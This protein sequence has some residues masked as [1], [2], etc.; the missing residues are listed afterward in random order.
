MVKALDCS[1]INS[2]TARDD[3]SVFTVNEANKDEVKK[4]V[5]CMLKS[6]NVALDSCI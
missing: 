5:L 6:Y 3:V 2:I 4:K 1:Y